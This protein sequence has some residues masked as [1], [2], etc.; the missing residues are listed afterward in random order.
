VWIDVDERV[1]NDESDADTE[2]ADLAYGAD[3][4]DGSGLWGRPATHLGIPV[5]KNPTAQECV[6]AARSRAADYPTTY[7][8]LRL[9]ANLCLITNRGNVARM[10]VT[11]VDWISR[12][13]YLPALSLQVTFWPG[14]S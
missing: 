6:E 10:T 4:A 1:V 13:D 3:C 8:Q 5:T 14:N 7:K 2:E 12:N 11:K 9:G